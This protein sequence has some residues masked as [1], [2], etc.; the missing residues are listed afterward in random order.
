MSDVP[1]LD[2]REGHFRL[3]YVTALDGFRGLALLAVVLGHSRLDFFRGG[4]I[5]VHTFFILSGFLITCILVREWDQHGGIDL[6][7]FY[8]RR[9]RR[10]FPALTL[11]L[12]GYAVFLATQVL[13]RGLPFSALWNPLVSS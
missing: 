5:G 10:I 2:E 7:Q 4:V 1:G 13:M 12:I 9:A 11:V 3:G 8:L 6:R